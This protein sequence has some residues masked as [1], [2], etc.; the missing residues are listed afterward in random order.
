MNNLLKNIHKSMIHS[1]RIYEHYPSCQRDVCLC[2]S[3]LNFK[4]KQ[5]ILYYNKC[6]N[7]WNLKHLNLTSNK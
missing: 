1:Y 3:Y 7:S 4:N 5:D 2:I 6:Y